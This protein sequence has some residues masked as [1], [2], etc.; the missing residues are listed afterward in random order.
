VFTSV[1]GID[2]GSLDDSDSPDTLAEWDSVAHIQLL[3]AIEAEFAIEFDPAEIAELISVRMIRDR[4]QQEGA[5][6][7]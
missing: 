2:G 7:G 6:A 1:L 3:M 4:L 5:S